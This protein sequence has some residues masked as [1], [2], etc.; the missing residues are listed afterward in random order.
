MQQQ[1][2][3][4]TQMQREVPKCAYDVRTV[5]VPK[6]LMEGEAHRQEDGAQYYRSRGAVRG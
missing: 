5:L 4:V 2:T 3:V 1:Q 6:M